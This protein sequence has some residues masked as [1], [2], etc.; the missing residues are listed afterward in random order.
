MPKE[1]IR[2]RGKRKT[3]ANDDPP[4]QPTTDVSEPEPSVSTGI[5]PARA[6]MLAGQSIPVQT[7]SPSQDAQL[8]DS[9]REEADQTQ[10]IRGPRMESEFPFGV[11]D[12][13]VKAYFKSI[14]E[15]IKD[16][17]G[18]SSAGEEREGAFL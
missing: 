9:E 18:V 1:H 17:E 5:H 4:L 6:A 15:Q 3:K 2:K 13:D 16:W 12:P 7:H 11:L 14:E 8:E 10:W